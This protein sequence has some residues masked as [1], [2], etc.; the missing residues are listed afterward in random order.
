MLG[1]LLASSVSHAKPSVRDRP[2]V[3]QPWLDLHQA[4]TDGP[5]K[6]E[7]LADGRYRYD[8]REAGFVAYVS[9]DGSV[10][11][12][13]RPRSARQDSTQ[14]MVAWVEGF[15][16]AWVQDAGERD[17][18]DLEAPMP[19]PDDLVERAF[20]HAETIPWGPYGAPPILL[21]AGFSL[22]QPHVD[23]ARKRSQADFLRRTESMRAAMARES[24]KHQRTAVQNRVMAQVVAIWKDDSESLTARKRMVFELWDAVDQIIDP[25][26]GES[27]ADEL[28]ARIEAAIRRLAPRGSKSAFTE[29]EIATF[30][31]RRRTK[32]R[33]APYESTDARG[34]SE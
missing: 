21:S 27:A 28:R 34:T 7:P 25:N 5:P 12:V 15:A 20:A 18:P 29:R 26:D 23:R 4:R 16:E 30:D 2:R 3:S 1:L 22:R 11:F 31:A 32:V 13:E 33:F 10:E 6:L 14:S 9:P 24:R 17:R 19:H 8:D